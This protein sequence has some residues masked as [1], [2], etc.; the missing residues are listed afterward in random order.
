MVRRSFS[1]TLIWG[2]IK[3]LKQIELSIIIPVYNSANIFPELYKRLTDVLEKS[4]PNFEIIAV[5]DG[6]KD[7][8]FEVISKFCNVDKRVKL[9]ELSRNFGHQAAVSA[10]LHAASGN[11]VIV[12]DDDLEDPPEVLP[13]LIAKLN[14]GF[15]VVYGIRRQRK[16]SLVHRLLYKIYYRLLNL[17]VDIKMPC[18]VGDFCVMKNKIVRIVNAMPERNMYLRGLRSWSGFKQTGVEYERKDR[19]ANKPGYN[20]WKYFALAFDAI[21]SFSYKPL[22][23]VTRIGFIVAF[24]SL[25]FGARLL[26]LKLSGQVRDVPGWV[27]LMLAVIF[28]AGLQLISIGVIGEYIARIYDEVKQRPKYIINR[29]RNIGEEAEN[30]GL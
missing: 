22:K 6:C 2:C 28:F 21:F 18:D 16:R 11:L 27:S 15:D 9:V 4:V 1:L 7:Q 26:I 3:L 13:Q 10:G 24:L 14:E 19:Y 30:N 25:V 29:I 5:L 23:I 8:S 17:L 20:I 12:M